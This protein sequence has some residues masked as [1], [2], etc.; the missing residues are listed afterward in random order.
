MVMR[1][2]PQPRGYTWRQQ[3]LQALL[4]AR[5]NIRVWCEACGHAAIHGPDWAAT[6]FGLPYD[7]T[8][9][10]VAQLLVCSQCGSRRVGIETAPDR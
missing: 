10:E 7:T 8:L 3:T 9:Y 5:I 2:D 1:G 6:S 4:K